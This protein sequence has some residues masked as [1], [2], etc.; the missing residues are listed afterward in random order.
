MTSSSDPEGQV[1]VGDL[2]RAVRQLEMERQWEQ[3][4]DPKN[5]AM[6]LVSEAGELAAL[7]RWV[8]NEQADAFME[9]TEER[10]R[11]REEIGD[12]GICLLLLCAR[13]N[14]SLDDAVLEKLTRI[15]EKYPTALAKGRADPPLK[16]VTE[17]GDRK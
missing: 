16:A 11:F 1:T 3:F 8:P 2:T 14:I 13:T 9:E 12:V 17:R 15:R 10:A 7:L 5:L 4:H 6:A